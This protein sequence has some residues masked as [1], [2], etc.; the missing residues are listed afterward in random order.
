GFDEDH[1]Y[2]FSYRDS[3]GQ[4]R[5]YLNSYCDDGESAGDIT[6]CETGLAEKSDLRFRFDFGDDWRFNLRL[7]K[8]GPRAKG[9]KDGQVLESKGK[10][11]KQYRS[12]E[13]ESDF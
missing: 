10:A 9:V 1:M 5:I 8:I 13:D 2:E 12:E 4:K 3:T 6:L 7:E 11:P